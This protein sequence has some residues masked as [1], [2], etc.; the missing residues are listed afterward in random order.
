MKIPADVVGDLKDD[1]VI[2]EDVEVKSIIHQ[3]LLWPGV[4]ECRVY[5]NDHK[6]FSALY[7]DGVKLTEFCEVKKEEGHEQSR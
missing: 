5:R 7:D 1:H 2:V 6:V 3:G 4:V